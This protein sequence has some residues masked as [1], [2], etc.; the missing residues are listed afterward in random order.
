MSQFQE[1]AGQKFLRGRQERTLLRNAAATGNLGGGNVRTAL[2]EQAAGIA[3][4]QFG[5]YQN[6]LAGLS[7]QGQNA[8]NNQ[9]L[10]GA[11]KA[12]QVANLYQAGGQARASGILGQKQA[13]A[14][15]DTQNNQLLGDIFGAVAGGVAGKVFGPI[16]N[17]L[18]GKS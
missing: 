8:V 13:T 18:L 5:D 9:A 2:Q 1:S 14:A 7:G 6:R 3:Q 15:R 16:L 4:Q 12:G 10:L 17:P 11:N